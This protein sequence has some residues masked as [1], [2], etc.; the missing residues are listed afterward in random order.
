MDFNSAIQLLDNLGFMDVIIPFILIFTIV[1]AILQKTLIL[2]K[3]KKNYNIVVAFSMGFLVVVTHVLGW[4]P[5]SKDPVEIL[6][7]FLPNISLLLVGIVMFLL[8]IGLL[9]GRA[10]WMGGSLSGWIA[11]VSMAVVIIMFGRSAGWWGQGN[12]PSWLNWFNDPE[13]QALVVIILIFG[14]VIWFITKDDKADTEG[15]RMFR[16]LGDFFGKGNAE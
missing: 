12:W 11:I 1:F 6:N 7:T 10:T 3:E 2:G 13:T 5:S 15:F 9:G 8:L 16:D 14:I 4:V